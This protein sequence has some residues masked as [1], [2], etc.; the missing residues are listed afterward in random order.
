MA[1]VGGSSTSNYYTHGNSPALPNADWCIGA[2]VR[3]ISN[4]GTGDSQPYGFEDVGPN[5]AAGMYLRGSA[6]GTNPN[7]WRGYCDD[8][9]T[10]DINQTASAVSPIDGSIYWIVWQRDKTA[11]RFQLYH[12]SVEPYGD[13]NVVR[14]VNFSNSTFTTATPSAVPWTAMARNASVGGVGTTWKQSNLLF[15]T[16]VGYFKFDS[17]LLADLALRGVEQTLF[18]RGYP[19]KAWHQY[20][21]ADATVVDRSGNG[22]H[23]TLSGTFVCDTS[24][25][26]KVYS[27]KPFP[28]YFIFS[29]GAAPQT[30][31]VSAAT[32]ASAGRTV[33]VV[34]GGV[35]IPAAAGILASA[36]QAVTVRSQVAIPASAGVITSAG[37]AVTVVPGGVTIPAA[38]GI[39]ASAG[40]AVTVRSQ[41]AIPASAGV[42][43]SAGQAVT[44]VPGGATVAASAGVIASA[45][46]TVTVVPG[47]VTVPV[48]TGVIASAGQS[49]TV[50]PGAVSIPVTAGV[51]ASAGQAVTVSVGVHIPISAGVIAS[52]GRTATVIPGA[53]AIPISAGVLASA[54]RTVTVVPGGISVPVSAGVIASVG[55]TVNVSIGT[56]VTVQVA[57]ISAAGRPVTV[58]PGATAVSIRVG[59]IQIAGQHVT[60]SLHMFAPGLLTTLALLPPATTSARLLIPARTLLAVLAA[61]DVPAAL[62]VPARTTDDLITFDTDL[63]LTP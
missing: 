1:L 34:P 29:G 35:T 17:G 31:S 54:G 11:N 59:A 18:K 43:T 21:A 53:V 41:V 52:A 42:I 8:D 22:N 38:A 63:E 16:F 61:A 40:Q 39:L 5:P 7:K 4:T 60:V 9:S 15:E 24:W 19:L 37:Q 30:V 46:R 44:V 14:L 57:A 25:D 49:A 2:L 33:T 20:H 51:L 26:S 56:R 23:A 58:I 10:I 45:G 62:V 6:S 47:G 36:G 3:V 27:Y 12:V 13:P 50:V 32:I 48:S 55:Q 28:V